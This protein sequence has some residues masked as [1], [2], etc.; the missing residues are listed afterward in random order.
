MGCGRLLRRGSACANGTANLASVQTCFPHP[1]RRSAPPCVRHLCQSRRTGGSSKQPPVAGSE[2]VATTAESCGEARDRSGVFLKPEQLHGRES[3]H[4][5]GREW[6]YATT[7][8]RRRPR[9]RKKQGRRLH[10]IG[11]AA[12]VGAE[13]PGR[14]C[15][16]GGVVAGEPGRTSGDG[17]ERRL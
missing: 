5:Q 6:E 7:D 8:A 1:I 17:G 10:S 16:V 3:P 4:E 2:P 12:L 11:G 9:C 14:P 13:H 15:R